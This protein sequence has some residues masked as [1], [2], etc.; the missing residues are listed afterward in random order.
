M[1]RLEYV[2]AIVE[3]KN[4]TRAAKRL[5]ITQPTLTKYINQLE[6]EY[7]VKLFDR[8]SNPIRLTEAGQLYV[9]K[10]LALADGERILRNQLKELAAKKITITIGSG[11]SRGEKTLPQALR[12]F[13]QNHPDID[14]RVIFPDEVDFYEKLKSGVI[15]IAFGVIDVTNNNDIEY[16]EITVETVGILIPLNWKILP[17]D[18]DADNTRFHPYPITAD[19]LNGKDVIIPGRSTG[20]NISF[21]EML[22]KYNIQF[23]RIVTADSM[24]ILKKMVEYGLGYSFVSVN[25]LP[26]NCALCTI[27]GLSMKRIGRCAYLRTHLHVELLRELSNL[28]FDS[29][30]NK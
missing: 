19:I 6:E 20:S 16:Q 8:T 24:V 26:P 25:M 17:E 7:G 9:Q 1:D 18:L 28:I 2:L 30:H 5:Y 4:I 3:E 14:I 22:Q 15:D 12:L 23:G 21:M 13:C 27:P 29:V 10:K 11:R